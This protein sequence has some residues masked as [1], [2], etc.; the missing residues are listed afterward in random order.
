MICYKYGMLGHL[1]SSCNKE[2]ISKGNGDLYG[3]WLR[4][5]PSAHIS[6]S[7]GTNLRSVELL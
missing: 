7:E 4:V 6:I 5:E 3:P 2:A 1:M